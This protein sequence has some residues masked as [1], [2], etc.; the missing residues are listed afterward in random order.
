MDRREVISLLEL[1]EAF[2]VGLEREAIVLPGPGGSFDASAVERIR[3][4]ATLQR[5]LGVNLE[6]VEVALHL[7]EIIAD[8]RREFAE[9][10]A[11]LRERMAEEG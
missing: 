9:V 8:E 5:E 4:C 6:G 2:L 7:M 1:D 10:L 11:W 3:L